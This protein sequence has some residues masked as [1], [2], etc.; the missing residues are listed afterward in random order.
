MRKRITFLSDFGHTDGYVGSVKGKILSINPETEIIDITHDINP[1]QIQEAAFVLSTYYHQFP[2]E[3]VHLAVVDPG[4]GSDRKPL[5]L[6]TENHTFVGPDNGLFTY[7]QKREIIHTY[8]IKQLPDV[9]S[10]TFH[11][12]DLFAPVAA[13]LTLGKQPQELGERITKIKTLPESSII[14]GNEIKAQ[15]VYVDHFGTMVTNITR[16]DIKKIKMWQILHVKIGRRAKIP[17]KKTYND[18]SEGALLA[19]WGSSGHLEIAMNKGN[20]A[21]NLN[22]RAGTTGISI[23]LK[24]RCDD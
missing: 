9:I 23:F 14:E 4:V 15:V 2:A 11:A 19:L 18:V 8:Q 17:F 10:D 21:Q 6:V 24:K 20:A 22:C 13:Y 5:I 7:I 16:E 3:T 1:F 12:R